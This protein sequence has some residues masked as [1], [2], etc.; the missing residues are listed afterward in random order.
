VKPYIDANVEVGEFMRTLVKEELVPVG[1]LK[2]KYFDLQIMGQVCMTRHGPWQF[3]LFASTVEGYGGGHPE[4]MPNVSATLLPFF[5]KGWKYAD[6]TGW[7]TAFG[8]A[9]NSPHKEEAFKFINLAC[10]PEV[11]KIFTEKLFWLFCNKKVLSP[12]VFDKHPFLKAYATAQEIA[13]VHAYGLTLP[14]FA[15]KSTE[16]WK[17][18]MDTAQKILYTNEN[19]A[20]LY[21]QLQDRLE[22]IAKG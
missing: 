14:G 5:G 12:D 21:V 9:K 22:T 4:Q 7:S 11:C 18:W 1:T 6:E 20:D 16:M 19:I 10:S 3:G 2:P 13:E 17:A 8:I 15:A